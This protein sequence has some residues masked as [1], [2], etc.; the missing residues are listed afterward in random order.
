MK[1]LLLP[2]LGDQLKF[3]P[4][5]SNR[6]K[7]QFK[8]W[9]ICNTSHNFRPFKDGDQY[10]FVEKEGKG[11]ELYPQQE[12][13]FIKNM[14]HKLIFFSIPPLEVHI[15]EVIGYRSKLS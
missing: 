9:Q 8:R 1:I 15:S 6:H 2:T 10:K 7:R 5:Y 4:F 14:F 13:P 11:G 12:Q 3:I